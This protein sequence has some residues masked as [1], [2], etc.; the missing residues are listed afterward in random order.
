MLS[1][2]VWFESFRTTSGPAVSLNGLTYDSTYGVY[3]FTF[4]GAYIPNIRGN[5]NC[6]AGLYYNNTHKSDIAAN[7]RDANIGILGDNTGSSGG[8]SEERSVGKECVSTCSSRWSPY[9]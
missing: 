5:S 9:H 2:Q 8:R 3:T 1:D 7:V 4:G 6:S